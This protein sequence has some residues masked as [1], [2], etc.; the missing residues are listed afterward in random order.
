[1]YYHGW[2]GGYPYPIRRVYVPVKPRP[3]KDDN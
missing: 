3:P 2:W 1:L